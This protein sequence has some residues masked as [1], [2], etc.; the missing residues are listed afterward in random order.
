M[1]TIEKLLTMGL[2]AS[3]DLERL[4][5]GASPGC[6]GTPGTRFGWEDVRASIA[7][8]PPE[9]RAVLQLKAVPNLVTPGEAEALYL[10][11][12]IA[13]KRQPHRQKHAS[14][15]RT[16]VTEYADPRTCRRCRGSGEVLEYA[17]GQGM[18]R[19]TCG[20]CVGRGWVSWSDNRRARGVAC[21]RAAW[22]HLEPAYAETLLACRRL[23]LTA[24]ARF[25][26]ELFGVDEQ[27]ELERRLQARC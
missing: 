13:L 14:I 7:V 19:G 25:K 26:R 9:Q 12:L 24:V 18:L 11:L 1:A 20:H 21:R 27:A 8:L 17:K 3:P 10:H 23:Y 6:A 15:I 5:Q 4:L 2:A 22:H 16:A